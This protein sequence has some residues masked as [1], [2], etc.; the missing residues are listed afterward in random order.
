MDDGWRERGNTDGD[1]LR[2]ARFRCAVPNPLPWRRDD[3][4][5]RANVDHASLVFD[6]HG[7]PKHDRDLLEFRPLTGLLPALRRDHARHAD[8][9]MAG[10][11]AARI[12]F[13]SLR[14]GA[15][16]LDDRGR[17]DESGHIAWILSGRWPWLAARCS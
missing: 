16:G 6:T 3:R 9:A 14:L 1:V 4:L 11:H 17:G 8:A 2:A 5:P 15:G 10:I 12:L 7:S 13:D